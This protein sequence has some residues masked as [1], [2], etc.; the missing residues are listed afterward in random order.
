VAPISHP[1]IQAYADSSLVDGDAVGFKV[2][3]LVDVEAAGF[4]VGLLVDGDCVGLS[5]GSSVP[6]SI[7]KL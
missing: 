3:M 1:N 4:R 7:F 2:G 6:H 5:V